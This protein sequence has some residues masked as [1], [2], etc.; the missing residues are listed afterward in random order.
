MT[1]PD[2]RCY[3]DAPAALEGLVPELDL[4]SGVEVT[5]WYDR[6]WDQIAGTLGFTRELAAARASHRSGMDPIAG[7]RRIGTLAFDRALEAASPSAALTEAH[8]R[9]MEATLSGMLAAGLA[10]GELWHL[11]MDAS[12]LP[13]GA[14]YDAGDGRPRRV[15]YP[16]TAPG[17]F[18]SGWSGPPPQA[19]SACG[20][21][22]PVSL[23]LGTF[24]WVYSTRLAGDGPG[25]RWS[26][27]NVRPA[28]MA[29]SAMASLMEP[30][31]NLR[32][33]ARQV[34]AIA[35]H[36]IA[37]TDAL[38]RR[39]PVFA[40]G[41]PSSAGHLFVKGRLLYAH[42]GSLHVAHLEGPRGALRASAYNYI[43]Q[44]FA[45]FFEVRRAALRA[46]SA[47]P[48]AVRELAAQSNDPC[49]RAHVEEARRAAS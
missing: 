3:G 26:A 40:A 49:L 48:E 10:T 6:A 20:W 9:A 47:L 41:R 44:R 24:P 19:A 11:R 34:A 29:M 21:Q 18:S 2:L 5:R 35:H 7:A 31:M 37:H 42:Q 28:T 8:A 39:L 1:T 38:V 36:F 46:F 15:F 30:E 16:D 43:L 17:L 33:D 32:A 12:A 4:R 27:G 23:F 25:T 14:C 13:G 45:C 22:T